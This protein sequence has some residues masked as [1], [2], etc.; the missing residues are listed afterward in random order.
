RANAELVA[1]YSKTVQAISFV[2]RLAD[3]FP[4]LKADKTYI[5]LMRDLATLETEVQ[6]R[7]ELYNSQARDFNTKRNQFPWDMVAAMLG[8]RR[9]PYLDPSRW[10]PTPLPGSPAAEE[11]GKRLPARRS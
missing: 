4:D 5:Q 3:N 6:S 10:Y 8:P 2:T 9:A 11:S 1:T 7:Y